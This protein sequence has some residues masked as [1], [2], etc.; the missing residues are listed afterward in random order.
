MSELRGNRYLGILFILL[1]ITWIAVLFAESSQPPAPIMGE[2]SGLDKLAH[3]AAFAVLA[4]LICLA[5][6]SVHGKQAIPVF[7]L[8]LLTVVLVGSIEEAYQ[9]TVPGRAGSWQDLV[10]DVSGGL[11]TIVCVNWFVLTVCTGNRS[12]R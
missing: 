2:I 1:S 3:F 10:A 7:S 6:L 8:P 11:F 4:V 5:W 12:G 9:M